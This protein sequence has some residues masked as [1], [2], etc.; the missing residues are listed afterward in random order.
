MIILDDPKLKHKKRVQNT[1]ELLKIFFMK[2]IK[3]QKEMAGK[4]HMT[5]QRRDLIQRNSG[6]TQ[7]IGKKGGTYTLK[8]KSV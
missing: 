5:E 1:P 8:L 2:T 7:I 6:K 4:I 3:K